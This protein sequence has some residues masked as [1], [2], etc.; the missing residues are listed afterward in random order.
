MQ[1]DPLTVPTSMS[2]LPLLHLFV[3]AEIGSA[4]VV[5]ADG[6]VVGLVSVQ[7]LMRAVDQACDDDV[8][9]GEPQGP[10]ATLRSLTAGDLA[11]SEVLW[12]EPGAPIA[13]VAREMRRCGAHRALVGGHAKVA[14][15]LTTF[16]LLAA[17]E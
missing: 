12:V 6:L 1:A 5:D 10:R 2:F 17:L 9:A 11:G 4:P 14:G 16:D 13:G 3:E 15:V 7:D 8:D